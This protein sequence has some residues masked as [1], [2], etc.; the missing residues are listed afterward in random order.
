MI[1]IVGAVIFGLFQKYVSL[2]RLQLAVGT[3]MMIAMLAMGIAWP[4]Y[5]DADTWRVVVFLYAFAA[6][7]M[8]MWILKQ[9]RDFLSMF[10]LFGMIIAGVVGVFVTNPTINMPAFVGWEVKGLISSRSS[11]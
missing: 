6:S 10:L 11:S 5:A 2:E 9:P 4:I 1:Y 8:P 7:V 3:R